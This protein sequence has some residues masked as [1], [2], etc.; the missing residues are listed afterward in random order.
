MFWRSQEF[1]VAEVELLNTELECTRLTERADGEVYMKS[2][3]NRSLGPEI[4]PGKDL[5]VFCYLLI[6][7]RA[8]VNS[9]V[10][11]SLVRTIQGEFGTFKWFPCYNTP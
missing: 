2:F 7:L 4:H 8:R 6:V 1:C 9:C 11:Y 3:A 5:R 10:L